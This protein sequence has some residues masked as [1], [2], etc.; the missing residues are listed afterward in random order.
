MKLIAL[1][2]LEGANVYGRSS[3]VVLRIDTADQPT[4]RTSLLRR[5]APRLPDENCRSLVQTII[6]RLAAHAETVHMGALLGAI[7]SAL[8]EERFQRD[9]RSVRVLPVDDSGVVEVV[10]QTG[11]VDVSR[12]AAII[13]VKICGLLAEEAEPETKQRESL[14]ADIRLFWKGRAAVRFNWTTS[15]IVEAARQLDI[16]VAKFLPGRPFVMLGQGCKR[17]RMMES[18]SDDVSVMAATLSKDK[19]IASEILRHNFLPVPEQ[20]LVAG[21]SDVEEAVLSI[22]PPLVVKGR[23][24]DKGASVST[25]ITGR[26][27]L[28]RA[29][30]KVRALGDQVI[31]QSH[32]PGDDYR[33]TVA[34]GQVLAAARLVPAHVVGDGRKSVIELI[35]TT[36]KVR[37]SENALGHWFVPLELN[38]EA[39]AELA[40]AGLEPETIPDMG[41]IVRLSG[42]A[43]ISLGGSAVDV[44]EDMHPSIISQ[45][46]RA[47]DAFGLSIAGIDIVTTDISRPL[48]ETGGVFIEVNATPGI[49]PHYLSSR[50]RDVAR[51]LLQLMFPDEDRGRIP[52]VGVTG[53]NG[54]TTSC[55]MI[56]RIFER[57]GSVVGMCST[58]GIT[59]GSDVLASGDFATGA[60]AR[61]VLRD[62]RV[63]VGVFELARGGILRRGLYLDELD[64]AAVVNVTD[65]HV[66]QDGVQSLEALARVK[67]LVAQV[68]RR[69]VV[70]NADDELCVDMA[71]H[72][73]APVWWMSQSSSNEL[74]DAH[75]QSGGEALVIEQIAGSDSIVFYQGTKATVLVQVAEIPATVGGLAKQNVE[76]A[77]CAA[78]V[79]LAIGLAPEQI[80][81]GLT[82]FDNSTA[83]NPG[84]LNMRDVDGVRL[85]YD[86]VHNVAGMRHMGSLLRSM[87]VDGRRLCLLAHEGKRAD[88]FFDQ[89]AEAAADLFDQFVVSEDS[90]DRSREDGEVIRLLREGL[91]RAGVDP[92]AI[93]VAPDIDDAVTK[94]FE[95]ARPGDLLLLTGGFHR[96][97]WEHLERF[98]L[99]DPDRRLNASRT[100]HRLS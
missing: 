11:D 93:S 45:C 66:A 30:A 91:L 86:Y 63:E 46:R 81:V 28:K 6:D 72:V 21:E 73:T 80:R 2:P 98:S 75:R 3:V 13:A 38:D 55:R 74:V 70:L 58:A 33:V 4:I 17:K 59:I 94:I 50:P 44:T 97:M 12:R 53:T 95:L 71:K 88:L 61:A 96:P 23:S 42:P 79:C 40:S 64:V 78:A 22:G 54:K 7:A 100:G 82:S 37:I 51:Q 31:I 83:S 43:N 14:A 65:D 68:A 99:A 15:V 41:Q 90:A 76:N 92:R 10:V 89:Y 49:R 36:N 29:I 57:A 34:Y 25:D 87:P 8:E 26:R 85:L 1:K 77:L 60:S 67:C 56:T 69:A 18:M 52:T 32:V 27:A 19:I 35:S 62:P 48:A 47:A 24:T 9:R 39:R 16:P 5:R 84:R 20:R